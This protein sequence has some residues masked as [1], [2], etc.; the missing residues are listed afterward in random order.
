MLKKI[1]RTVFQRWKLLLLIL[2]FLG[3]MG[4]LLLKYPPTATDATALATASAVASWVQGVGTVLAVL[5]AGWIARDQFDWQQ[6]ADAQRRA[7][8]QFIE[9][10]VVRDTLLELASLAR[11]ADA[12]ANGPPDD[13][14]EFYRTGGNFDELALSALVG[15][16]GRATLSAAHG[17]SLHIAM[18][19]ASFAAGHLTRLTGVFRKTADSTPP[20]HHV[21]GWHIDEL[22]NHREALERALHKFELAIEALPQH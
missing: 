14:R 2:I 16:L 13:F 9:L 17:P 6:L 21:D 12:A 8:E 15:L 18:S 20:R 10:D 5:S 3:G 4:G 1:R 7:E 11:A 19:K 22:S